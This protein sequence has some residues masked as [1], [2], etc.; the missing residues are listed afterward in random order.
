MMRRVGDFACGNALDGRRAGDGI[1]RAGSGLSGVERWH[2][3]GRAIA[4]D[5]FG[6]QRYRK[7]I[8]EGPGYEPAAER[9][10]LI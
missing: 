2:Q 5:G 9:Y 6:S 4:A 8:D 1:F 10:K 3:V 7:V